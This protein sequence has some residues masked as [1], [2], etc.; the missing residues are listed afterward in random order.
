MQVNLLVTEMLGGSGGMPG[1]AMLYSR[2]A[3]SSRSRLL[4][5]LLVN[6]LAEWDHHRDGP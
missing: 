5:L 3:S 6:L 4:F 1:A 2:I